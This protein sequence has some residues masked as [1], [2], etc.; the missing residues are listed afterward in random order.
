[1]NRNLDRIQRN[2]KIMMLAYD[3]GLEHGP[4]DF[5]SK[6]YHPEYI[7][8][9]ASQGKYT[10]LAMQYANARKFW[11]PK[12]AHVPMIVKLN[13]KTKL[14]PEALSVTNASVDEA[15][16]IG[17][18][19]VGFTI[20]LGSDHEAEMIREFSEI[21]RQAHRY[22]LVVIAW[23]YP[24]ITKPSSN[25]DELEADIVAYAAR[26]GAE[27]GADVVKIKY[28]RQPEKLPWII[29]NAVGTKAILSGGDK[30]SDEDFVLKVKQF[31]NAGGAGVAVGR[32]AWQ[33]PQPLFITEKTR[34][35]IWPE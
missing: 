11:L 25:D 33:H 2:G 20:Y 19:G 18:S 9:I 32:N 29:K 16:G 24:F 14:G 31:M 7:C 30:T 26:A 34:K 4:E 22:G 1:M 28:P 12:Y 6:N 8:D 23:M 3:Q 17:A 10:C 27:L 15:I 35:V 13:G 21:R 5:D